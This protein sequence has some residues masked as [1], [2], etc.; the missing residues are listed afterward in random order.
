MMTPLLKDCSGMALFAGGEDPPLIRQQKDSS[1][2]E[3]S[4]GQDSALTGEWRLHKE[5]SRALP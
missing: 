4:L 5:Q 2:T 1:K 3:A